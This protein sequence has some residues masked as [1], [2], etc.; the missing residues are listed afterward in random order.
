LSTPQR[1]TT[2]AI[3]Y[4]E[5]GQR[6]LDMAWSMKLDDVCIKP[7][8]YAET[9]VPESLWRRA[10]RIF[11][12]GG[13]FT[14][15]ALDRAVPGVHH[16]V[17]L[18]LP[19]P[20]LQERFFSLGPD[21]LI[22]NVV[23][24][25]RCL[26]TLVLLRLLG[27]S[28]ERLQVIFDQNT[29]RAEYSHTLLT[30]TPDT[31]ISDL[32]LT[33]NPRLVAEVLRERCGGSLSSCSS[34]LLRAVLVRSPRS[35]V[36][37]VHITS[38][39]GTQ[40]VELVAALREH[41]DLRRVFLFGACGAVVHEH[42]MNDWVF[43]RSV[44]NIS[45]GTRT[46]GNLFLD[47][48]DDGRHESSG[49]TAVA[50]GDAA[51]VACIPGESA[52]DLLHLAKLGIAVVDLELG[53]LTDYVSGH[54][55][56]RWGA[57]LRVSDRPLSPGEQLPARKT[58]DA[59]NGPVADARAQADLVLAHSQAIER[60]AK[61]APAF[62]WRSASG[63]HRL[64]V[65]EATIS[66]RNAVP[67]TVHALPLDLDRFELL[68]SVNREGQGVNWRDDIVR[69]MR[70]WDAAHMESIRTCFRRNPCEL[71]G[72]TISS[73]RL[74]AIVNGNGNLFWNLG[75]FVC[76]DG[77]VFHHVREHLAGVHIALVQ[78][79]PRARIGAIDVAAFGRSSWAVS[80]IRILRGG[81]PVDL[82]ETDPQTGRPVA[83]EF[84][85]DLSHI[86]R[87]FRLSLGFAQRLFE[88][89]AERLPAQHG[90]YC[91]ST[92]VS[93]WLR[94][95][96]AG[97]PVTCGLDD[98]D[99]RETILDSC[100]QHGYREIAWGGRMLA[101][102][103]AVNSSGHMAI[104]P[105]RATLGHSVLVSTGDP[106]CLILV[107]TYTDASRKGFTIEDTA[108]LA[109][110]VARSLGHDARE[111]LLLSSS[112]DPR[113]ILNDG[114]RLACLEHDT[115]GQRILFKGGLDYGLSNMLLVCEKRA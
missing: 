75:H 112:G 111:A 38:V 73:N 77:L 62:S 81:D 6:L 23:G 8:E 113:I 44:V 33:F 50:V 105:L 22:S 86:V 18:A 115:D 54:T 68:P 35:S 9:A 79:G 13:L 102:D 71:A 74:V 27:V 48:S 87:G 57:A 96:L 15:S 11:V 16:A 45:R 17:E 5:A 80:G 25:T 95:A 7:E 109:R 66:S 108:D 32:V 85:G 78:D 94:H 10:R 31:E 92:Q 103:V 88:E 14:P 101:G 106:D 24:Q 110:R 3:T 30:L 93:P 36:L 52:A 42:A 51:S 70:A 61:S 72:E 34:P 84:Y 29:F 49:G 58:S 47:G 19:H 83:T 114:G 65:W 90:M 104:A 39:Y 98:A 67:I 97:L 28:R 40:C 4:E 46:A 100:R 63:G 20:N 69:G 12:H 37:L 60:P 76:I 99:E 56:L 26:H 55:D 2:T 53:P 1:H 107:N 41:F 21:G 64:K 89:T 59:A 91:K 43:P 82:L